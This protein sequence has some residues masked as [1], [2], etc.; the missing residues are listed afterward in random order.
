MNFFRL[1]PAI[2]SFLL[3]AA[4]FYRGGELFL[5]GVSLLLIILLLVR[6]PWVSWLLQA[7]LLLGAIE[8]LWTLYL[9][10]GV[11]IE[12]GLPW[13]RMSV[14]LGAVAAFTALSAMVFWGKKVRERYHS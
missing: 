11:R 8:W 12:H 6:Q 7:C 4:H 5:V 10:A 13:A 3:L 14:I 1:L 9:I 2:L